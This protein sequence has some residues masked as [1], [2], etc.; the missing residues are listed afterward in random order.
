MNHTYPRRPL[1]ANPEFYT[2][3]ADGNPLERSE[4]HLYFTDRNGSHVWRLPSK[5][6]AEFAKPEV[7]W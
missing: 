6:N 3:W 4:S 5:M 1:D 2:L 7:A